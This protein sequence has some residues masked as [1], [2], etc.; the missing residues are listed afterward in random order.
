MDSAFIRHVIQQMM[1]NK[2]LSEKD[3]ETAFDA[4]MT[5][6][7]TPIQATAIIIM[8]KMKGETAKE[9]AVLSQVARKYAK[10]CF[11]LEDAVDIVGTG[12]DNL[13]TFNISTAAAFVAA[14]AGAKVVKV[15]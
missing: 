6:K 15:W 4:I 11:T 14:G 8:I 1:S 2:E 3:L 5:G 10:P 9:L 7:T 12:G 13:E